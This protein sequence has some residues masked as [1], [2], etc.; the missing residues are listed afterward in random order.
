MKS[1][2]LALLLLVCLPRLAPARKDSWHLK[3]VS[4]FS[5][6]NCDDGQDPMLIKSLTVKPVPVNIPGNI[7]VSMEGTTGVHLSSPI[8]GVVVMEKEVAPGIWFQLPC[9]KKIG[10]CIYKDVCE[11]IDY[12]IPPGVP[13]PEPFHTYGLP[14]HC[15]FKKGT[16]SLPKTV[17]QIPPLK[18]PPS[19]SSGTY[20]AHI[21]LSNGTTLRNTRL[22]CFKIMITLKEASRP[23]PGKSDH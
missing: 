9:Y 2:S 3:K 16:Y 11:T 18:L 13:C 20:R 22:G 4:D 12:F 23:M 17:F 5:W 15:P 19:L 1:F 10:S 7:T 14:C 21:V 6:E 8:K